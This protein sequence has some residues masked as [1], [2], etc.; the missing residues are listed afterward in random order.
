[1]SLWKFNTENLEMKPTH[2]CSEFLVH[3]AL[4]YN[5]TQT[6]NFCGSL[7]DQTHS[8]AIVVHCTHFSFL[9]VNFFLKASIVICF[10]LALVI[11]IDY[12]EAFHTLLERDTGVIKVLLKEIFP[13]LDYPSHFIVTMGLL[14]LTS[15]LRSG[16]DLGI[17]VA[18][19][20]ECLKEL[21]RP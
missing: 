5:G 14:Y 12:I 2:G 20:L 6:R 8:P 16:K 11:F 15:N 18:C 17:K 19:L 1:M 10:H 9:L 21:I 3:L 7:L 13:S 4:V